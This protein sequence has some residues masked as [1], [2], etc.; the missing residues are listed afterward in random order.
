MG[1]VVILR[2]IKHEGTYVFQELGDSA[3]VLVSHT[4]HPFYIFRQLGLLLAIGVL[5]MILAMSFFC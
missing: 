4:I 5:H 2:K 1:L 3:F